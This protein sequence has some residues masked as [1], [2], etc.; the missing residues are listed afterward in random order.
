ML[1]DPF[2]TA[3]LSAFWLGLLTAVSPCPLATNIAAISYIGKQVD[4]PLRAITAGLFYTAGRMITY[5]GIALLIINSLLSIPSI[6]LFLQ[7]QMNVI[8]GPIL[9]VTGILLLG[10]IPFKGFGGAPGVSFQQKLAG[11]GVWG[12]G[13]LG[14]LFAL[15]FCPVSAALFFGSLIPLAL[16]HQSGGVLPLSYGLG[17]AL[18]V[19]VFAVIIASGTKYIGRMFTGISKIEKYARVVTAVLFILIGIYFILTYICK[20]QIR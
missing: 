17:T 12:A 11:Q 1:S 10:L 14:I 15:S 19:V 18:P 8:M 5:I 20:I 13:L 16:E 6:A 3:L 7:R 9:L 2:V 4:S